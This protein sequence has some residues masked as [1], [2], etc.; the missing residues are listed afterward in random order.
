MV[1]L[2]LANNCASTEFSNCSFPVGPSSDFTV[3][4]S[5]ACLVGLLVVFFRLAMTWFTAL[6]RSG[7]LPP[8]SIRVESKPAGAAVWPAASF[9]FAGDFFAAA[10]FFA[11]S[12]AD[13]GTALL[14]GSGFGFEAAVFAGVF[15]AATFLAAGPAFFAGLLLVVALADRAAR[16][17]A[18]W[19]S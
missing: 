14:A 10:A 9:F 13:A 8:P 19:R 7:T 11:G 15:L 12:F 18:S 3:D 5:F 16:A 6:F 2:P 1:T 4:S 17:D